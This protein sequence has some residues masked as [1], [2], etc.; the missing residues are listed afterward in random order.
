VTGTPNEGLRCPGCG[1]PA[2]PDA[3]RCEYCHARL[4]TVS[5]P[6]CFGLLFEGAAFCRH[7]G[8][9][10]SRAEVIDGTPVRCPACKGEMKWISVG[11]T[12]LL[13]CEGCDG[14]WIEADRFERLCADRE[15]QAAII[16]TSTDLEPGA[17]RLLENVRY[18]P[19][20]R[21]GKLMN[22]I[23]FGRLSG[24]VVDVCKGHGTFLDR[25]ELHQVIR[26]IQTG[27]MDRAR[28][29]QRAQ[30]VEEERR[31]RDA[32]SGRALPA[33]PIQTETDWNGGMLHELFRSLFGGS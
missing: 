11:G 17:P 31:L 3:A 15:A 23:N 2:A 5:C 22:R 16:H 28:E 4:A 10:R 29:A 24:A 20:P 25:G 6:N 33:Q 13:E 1:A 26:F 8:A 7:C 32:E 19:C 27:G 21:C 14:T 18:R 30:L 12:E 9:P